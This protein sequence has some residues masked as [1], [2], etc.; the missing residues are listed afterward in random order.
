MKRFAAILNF[1]EKIGLLKINPF[2]LFQFHI[3]KK[4]PVYLTEDEVDLI[5]G[6]PL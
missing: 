5:T 4:Y 2:G 3:E 6:K 1:A